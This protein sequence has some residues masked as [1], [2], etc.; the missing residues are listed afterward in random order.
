[1]GTRA[2]TLARGIA[3][4]LQG[5]TTKSS[6]RGTVSRSRRFQ[7]GS[8]PP[9]VPAI[10]M[11]QCR[12]ATHL[13]RDLHDPKARS[14]EQP[15]GA[16]CFYGRLHE[17]RSWVSEVVRS[18][19][20]SALA[21]ARGLSPSR[22]E[23]PRGERR[24][25]LRRPIRYGENHHARRRARAFTL[26][27][28][29]SRF[30]FVRDTL[31]QAPMRVS[32]AHLSGIFLKCRNALRQRADRL[33]SRWLDAALLDA[34]PTLRDGDCRSSGGSTHRSPR[35]PRICCLLGP[36]PFSVPAEGADAK[37]LAALPP[38]SAKIALA[39]HARAFVCEKGMCMAPTTDARSC[40]E[41]ELLQGYLHTKP[42]YFS[43][44]M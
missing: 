30:R 42:L 8:S 18:H 17:S 33:G 34:G 4:A 13:W 31:V 16:G 12:S 22:V 7:A 38:L 1:M 3:R 40:F 23:Q 27:R 29:A 5:V 39:G 28:N 37:W 32:C 19:E 14:L 21:H 36:S 41:N 6:R 35:R 10:A 43:Y 9:A 2:A 15:G 25:L 44:K 20:R 26:R 11:L 24:W